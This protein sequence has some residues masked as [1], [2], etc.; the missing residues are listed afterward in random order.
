MSF[1]VSSLVRARE[2]DW[3]VLPGSTDTLLRLRPLGGADVEE[4]ALLP[5]LER[6]EPA[7]FPLPDPGRPG[8]ARSARLLRDAVRI[9]FRSSAGP[10][11]C[12]GGIAVEPRLYQLVPLLLALRLNPVRLLIADD[13]GIGKTIEALLVAK[14]L[15]ARGEVERLCVLCPPH[16]A[17]QWH[18]ELLSKFSLEAAL[19]LPSTVARLERECPRHLSVFE[20]F[21]VTVVSLDYI[22]QERRR[23]DFLRTCPELVV[24]DE[25]HTCTQGGQSAQH[26]FQLVQKL[27]EDRGRHLVLVTATPHSGNEQS[28]R[29][30]L[31]LLDPRFET[32]P[33]NL[34]G[35]H[36]RRDREALA[37]HFVQRRRADIR[38]YLREATPFPERL[39]AEVTYQLSNEQRVLLRRALAYAKEVVED[40]SGT[41][42]QQRLRWWSAL[43]LL[44]SIGSSPLAAFATLRSRFLGADSGDPQE[45]EDLWKRTLMDSADGDSAEGGDVAPGAEPAGAPDSTRRRFAELARMAQALAGPGDP[46][47][48]RL[49]EVVA[50]LLHDGFS[51]IVFCKFIP[52]AEYVADHLRAA[53]AGADVACVTG[54]LP[55]DEREERIRQIA[56]QPKRVLVCT[57]CLSEGINLQ[58]W[59]DAAVHADL[60]WSPTRHEQR[61]G[62]V[63][64]F[65]QA[66]PRVR[67]VTLYGKDN[68]V[69]GIVLGILLR[70]HR[71]IRDA[72]GVSVPVPA[73]SED[74]MEA[75]FESLL[76]KG[77]TSADQ[78]SLAFEE[79]DPR[80]PDLHREWDRS[81]DR[82]KRSRA[83][84]AQHG[85][86]VEEVRRELEEVREAVGSPADVERFVRDAVHASGGLVTRGRPATVD[87]SETPPALRD[88]V[89]VTAPKLSVVFEGPP[90]R[91]AVHLT[92]TH[93]FVEG[94]ATHV[95][96]TA[97]D[98]DKSA[99]AARCAV[100]VTDAVPEA[101]ALLV[102]RLRFQVVTPSRELL[103]EECALAAFRGLPAQARWL[104]DAEAEAL[105]DAPPRANLPPDLARHHLGRHL[106]QCDALRPALRDLAER[107][108]A[109]LL[110]AHRRVRKAFAPAAA[111]RDVRVQGD[112]D[113]VGFTLYLPH[114]GTV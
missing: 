27:S 38:E 60:A 49:A 23:D 10:L 9:G 99:V 57:D 3:V 91:G 29:S 56:D 31:S 22:K 1:S 105:L 94:L 106:A 71:T 18:G 42:F 76:L 6:V 20:H 47:L 63:D 64:R 50:D 34:S 86:R 104:D 88:A 70:K 48:K 14:E 108:A 93:P 11:R 43:A 46:K 96:E 113:I 62:R 79:L 67:V 25:A 77:A 44:R 92:R 109:R 4:T 85:I 24:V 111:A 68:P 13:V 19:V 30:M 74:V 52:T 84:F 110:E 100:V 17:E 72:L 7:T 75:I 5:A 102:L 66:S 40:R 89:A 36:H 32:L 15:L 8:D 45:A 95:L 98:G 83:L 87:L 55:H 58:E 81:A 16:L 41:H 21:P 39:D 35:E 53:L 78:L 61:E 103:A 73:R 101:T 26:R 59:F 80:V 107:R 97:L 82:E 90:P 114:G 69:D 33:D 28:F 37:A 2:R 54:R 65:G 12:L 112:P 51:P